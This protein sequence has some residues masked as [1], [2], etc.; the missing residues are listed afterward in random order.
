MILD[1]LIGAIKRHDIATV[2]SI[3]TKEADD[4]MALVKSVV[5]NKLQDSLLDICACFN[6]K[7][8][9]YSTEKAIYRYMR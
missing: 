9:A 8:V 6:A 4:R 3:L 1:M 5:E 2:E 7:G